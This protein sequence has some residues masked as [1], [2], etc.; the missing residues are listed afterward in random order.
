[1][2]PSELNRHRLIAAGIP[3]CDHTVQGLSAKLPDLDPQTTQGMS[4]DALA[5]VLL[6]LIGKGLVRTPV[7][8]QH[9]LLDLPW[10][11]HVCQFYN[12]KEDLLELLVPYFKQGLLQN[13][14]CVWMVA[15]LTIAEATS[16]L[17][18]AV[19]DLALNFLSGQMQIRHYTDLYTNPDGSVKEPEALTHAFASMG[20]LARQQGFNGLRASGCVSWV[21]DGAGMSRFMAYESKVNVAIQNARIK[22]V[23]TY[24]AHAAALSASR[25]MIHSHGKILVKRGS[26]VH[27]RSDEAKRIERVFAALAH[28]QTHS[29]G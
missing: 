2:Y 17:A 18:A 3:A 4:A 9:A 14:A 6:Y 8:S 10:G 28:E 16:A 11:A 15:E 27:D 1:M 13:E 7:L 21:R 20:R 12:R 5:E 24:P 23:C 22:A 26:W 25:E 29:H 19:P